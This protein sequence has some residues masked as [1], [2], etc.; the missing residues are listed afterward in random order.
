MKSKSSRTSNFTKKGK[1]GRPQKD[2]QGS[3]NETYSLKHIASLVKNRIEELF[4]EGYPCE[5][6]EAMIL[7]EYLPKVEV[8]KIY[9]G[10]YPDKYG[11]EYQHILLPIEIEIGFNIYRHRKTGKIIDTDFYNGSIFWW[12]Q[13]P[14]FSYETKEEKK[15]IEKLGDF[16]VHPNGLPLPSRNDLFSLQFKEEKIIAVANQ[17]EIN[18]LEPKT[19]LK[20]VEEEFNKFEEEYE[21]IFNNFWSSIKPEVTY[22]VRMQ[23]LHPAI[24]VEKKKHWEDMM[25][26]YEVYKDE[27]IA[28]LTK[29][30]KKK[31]KK[32]FNIKTIKLQPSQRKKRIL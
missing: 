1:V 3:K 29:Q 26:D 10:I 24:E 13:E 5:L 28:K 22:K 4:V 16:H 17:Q 31:F 18:I 11:K 19:P 2:D 20:S 8:E 30:L 23:L 15:Y 32:F 27:D 9:E 12:E 25:V 6:Q 14:K 7:K 21:R